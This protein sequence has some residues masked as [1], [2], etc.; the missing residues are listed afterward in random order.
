MYEIHA[1]DLYVLA[2]LYAGMALILLG[3]VHNANR[4]RRH[5]KAARR[6]EA[7]ALIHR[8]E[9]ARQSANGAAS[10]ANAARSEASCETW[11]GLRQLIAGNAGGKVVTMPGGVDVIE[12]A[13]PPATLPFP[14]VP[15][16]TLRI[17]RPDAPGRDNDRKGG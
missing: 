13:E 6:H 17:H 16:P 5:N 4:A 7:A 2:G 8:D 1:T 14:A 10:E 12:V 9:A 3:C 11:V 15:R